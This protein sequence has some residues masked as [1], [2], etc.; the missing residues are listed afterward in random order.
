MRFDKSD[1]A[2]ARCAAIT[3]RGHR[4]SGRWLVALP[5]GFE[6][7]PVTGRGVY[8]PNVVLCHR[9]RHLAEALKDGT[10][11]FRV[12]HGWLGSGNHY[13][14]GYAVFRTRSGWRAAKWWADRRKPCAFGESRRDAA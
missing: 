4:C 6:H 2:T 10:S 14:Y 11:R 7:N 8:G 9:H 5:C 13:G 3:R 1:Y 12:V